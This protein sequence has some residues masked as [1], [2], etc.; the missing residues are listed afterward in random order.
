MS[1]LPRRRAVASVL[2]VSVLG[3]LTASGA[4]SAESHARTAAASG[5]RHPR[6]ASGQPW[7]N[8]N[9]PALVRANELLAALGTDQKIQLALGNFAALSSFGVPTLTFDDGPD[10]VRNPGTTAMPSGQ[11][12]AAT[13]DRAL[14]YAYGQVVGSEARDE[15]F[16]EWT[17]PA[18]DID[19]TPLAG[20]QPEAEGEDPFLAGN[21]GAQVVSG[22]KSQH[23][24]VTLKHYTAYNQD[25][26][27]IGFDSIGA[28]AT[29]VV[30]S[31]RALQ[32]IYEEPFRIAIRE[33]GLDS[34]MCSYNQINGTPSCQNP[35]TLGDLKN[36]T[37]FEGF[38]VPDFMF[39]VRD[40]LAA[41]NAGVDLPAL[42][43]GG[44]GGLTAAEFTSGQISGSRLDDIDRRILFAIF[45][46]GL[47]DNPL[48][49]PSTEVST[50]Q[51][52]QVSTQVA[53]AATVLLKN[54]HQVL[55]LSH[56]VRSIAL[57][58]PTGNDAVF[59]TGG[60]AGVPL[61]AGQAI[62]PLAGI[63]AQASSAG[64][65]VTAVQG[66]AGDVASPTPVPASALT[67]S[68]GAGPGLFRLLLEQR[69]FQ[70][71]AGVDRGR[72]VRQRRRRHR[73]AGPCRGRRRIVVGEVDGDRHPDRVGPLQVHAVRGR[74]R[75]AQDR[76]ASVRTG[77]PRGDAV[78]RRPQL[79]A[80][81]RGRPDRGH[82][83]ADR[84]RLL[85]P[86]RAVQPGDPPGVADAVAVRDP[87]RGRCGPQR[88]RRGRVRQRRPGRGHGP[89]L[90]GASGRPGPADRSGRR[91]EPT[92]DRRAEHRRSGAHALAA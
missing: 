45:D 31:E 82:A 61:A 72:P 85:Q 84:D 81:G 67:P 48:P 52:Q 42:P 13:F 64:V 2:A 78:P 66:S 53:E 32:E 11:A 26:G 55:P 37:G 24:I 91:R 7:T 62:T 40:P 59:V 38:V 89:V 30:V 87:G 12:L 41:A 33:A 10:G 1:A 15:G 22:A 69:D 39:A 57:I 79:R 20:R 14:A 70:R 27:R 90:T 77:V 83:G 18:V 71:C 6:I 16:S 60:S 56:R 8:P 74:H 76:R 54:D 58:G 73:L 49:T 21:T 5:A 50:P 80:P 44:G 25:Y 68:S 63:T 17:G 28:P 75:D 88:R 51:H 43:G 92:D 3:L 4:S 34:V 65:D 47:F 29:D 23:V 9:Q 36:G 46:S 19:R 35:A 86:Q